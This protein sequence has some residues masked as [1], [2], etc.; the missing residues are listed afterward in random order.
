METHIENV[1]LVHGMA[2]YRATTFEETGFDPV[3]W[4]VTGPAPMVGTP[5]TITIDIAE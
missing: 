1:R 5:V 3:S 4:W 2:G